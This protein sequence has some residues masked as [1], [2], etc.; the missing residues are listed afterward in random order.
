LKIKLPSIAWGA[1]GVLGLLVLA[2]V[3]A[4]LIAPKPWLV[5][6]ETVGRENI[7]AHARVGLWWAGLAALPPLLLLAVTARWWTLPMGKIGHQTSAINHPRWF[8][9]MVGAAMLVLA[10]LGAF[11]LSHSLWDD[12]SYCVRKMILG[13]YRVKADGTVSVKTPSWEQTLWYYQMPANHGLQTVL[14]RICL[15]V[16]RTAARPG[17]LQLS[18]VAV[19]LPSY[20]AGILSIAALALLVARL[21]FPAEGVIAAWLFAVHPWH[22]RLSPEA[23][24]YA[25]VFLLV[26]LA[27]VLALRAVQTG[28]WKSLAAFALTEFVLLYTWPG[29]LLTVCALNAAALYLIFRQGPPWWDV[30][31]R[32]GRW[33]VCG[34]L[35]ATAL[36]PLVFPWLPQLARYLEHPLDYDFGVG[37]LK[38]LGALLLSGAQWTEPGAVGPPYLEL[39]SRAMSAPVVF[40]A[41]VIAVVFLVGAGIWRLWQ[42][43]GAARVLVP[44]LLLPGPAMYVLTRARGGHLHEWYLSFM[45]P[46]LLACAAL[47]LPRLGPRWITGGLAVVFFALL[48]MPERRYFLMRSVEPFRE[49]VLLTR[50]NL[51]PNAPENRSII[52]TCCL[53]T[54]VVYDPL[55]RKAFTGEDLKKLMREAD[56]R[57]ATL[58]ANNGYFHGVQDRYPEIHRLLTDETLFEMVGDLRG[59]EPCFDRMVHRYRP[60]SLPP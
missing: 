2:I 17:G 8:W 18:E 29:S 50:P 27:C 11:R 31:L 47:G 36:L 35:A 60:G 1:A 57:G 54:P 10:I 14:S 41:S 51:D 58:Y 24:G 9:P 34:L 55:V 5:D 15:D 3:A 48:T 28:S 21:G 59:S 49:S 38:N 13:S 53:I 45:L 23:R 32:S 19:R 56:A 16:W 26:P 22:L 52:T 4:L 39:C 43:G 33:L 44:V 7:K 42:K 30:F 6:L 46:A 25:F 12:E 40:F 37:W 20:L